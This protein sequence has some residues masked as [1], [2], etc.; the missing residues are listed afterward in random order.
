MIQEHSGKRRQ[1]KNKMLQKI[2]NILEFLRKFH[3]KKEKLEDKFSVSY[4]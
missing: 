4:F 1:N 3:F 2:K